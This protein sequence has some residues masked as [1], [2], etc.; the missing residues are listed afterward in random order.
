MIPCDDN[1]VSVGQGDQPVDLLLDVVGRARVGQ[2]SGMQQEITVRDIAHDLIMG[3]RQ[4][5]NL[6]GRLVAGRS[7]R[8]AAEEEDEMV[9]AGDDKL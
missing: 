8:L 1:L 2:V 9:N 7:E 5:D 3:I 4:T 6:D